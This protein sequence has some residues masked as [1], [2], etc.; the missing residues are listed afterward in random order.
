VNKLSEKWYQPGNC[1]FLFN[2]K[3]ISSLLAEQIKKTPN[4][5][6][7]QRCCRCRIS[8][9]KKTELKKPSAKRRPFHLPSGVGMLLKP[10][11]EE[12]QWND[13]VLSGI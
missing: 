8:E 11:M 13:I 2:E 7:R 12:R 4:E 6:G 10:G 5:T 1:R 9:K 3:T